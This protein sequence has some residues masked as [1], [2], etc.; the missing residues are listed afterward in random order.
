MESTATDL[1]PVLDALAGI[2]E[3]LSQLYAAQL[4]MTG[5][6]LGAMVILVLAVMWR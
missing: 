4:S 6:L 3:Q 1:T 5:V 2:S